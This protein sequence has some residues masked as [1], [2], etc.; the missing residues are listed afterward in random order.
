MNHVQA[1]RFALLNEI[2]VDEVID[3]FRGFE[4][5]EEED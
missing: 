4:V 2:E 1:E 3:F 5:S